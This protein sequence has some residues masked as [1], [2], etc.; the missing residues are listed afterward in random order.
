M[1]PR[2]EKAWRSMKR[3]VSFALMI[4]MVFA[5]AACGLPKTAVETPVEPESVQIANPWRDITE[6]EA[7]AICPKSFDVP[8]G[9]ENAVWSVMEPSG[10]QSALVQLAFDL[11]GMILGILPWP[12]LP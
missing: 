1:K 6:A 3:T 9:A 10:T 7:K 2:K 4:L 11:Y 5:L 12:Q 8:E